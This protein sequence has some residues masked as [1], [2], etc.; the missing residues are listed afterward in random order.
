M[1]GSFAAFIPCL[2][3]KAHYRAHSI[4]RDRYPLD[5]RFALTGST[6]VLNGPPERLVTAPPERHVPVKERIV[7]RP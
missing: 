5:V 2:P 7:D 4:L 1:F 6:K 3:S